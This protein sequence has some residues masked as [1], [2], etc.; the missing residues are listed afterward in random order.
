MTNSVPNLMCM[1][2]LRG[3]STTPQ[4]YALIIIHSTQKKNKKIKPE[5]TQKLNTGKQLHC[6]IAQRL[7]CC[8]DTSLIVLNQCNACFSTKYGYL[9]LGSGRSLSV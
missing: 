9:L 3:F 6:S 1:W 5:D 7:K 8:E 4:T 2:N